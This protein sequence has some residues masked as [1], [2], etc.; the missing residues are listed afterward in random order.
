MQER[1]SSLNWLNPDKNNF[2]QSYSSSTD[3]HLLSN[4]M[5]GRMEGVGVNNI[6]NLEFTSCTFIL[7]NGIAIVYIDW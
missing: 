7:I 5:G 2:I 6:H 4:R 1:Q 3:M